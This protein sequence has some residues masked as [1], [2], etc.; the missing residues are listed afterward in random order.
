MNAKEFQIASKEK[1]I[2]RSEKGNF[3]SLHTES[4]SLHGEGVI[5]LGLD[6]GDVTVDAVGIADYNQNSGETTMN[7]TARFNMP[8]DKGAL[9]GI[10]D[11][12][13][14]EEDL[15]PLDY[16]RSTLE[17]ALIEWSDQKIADRVKSDYTIRGEVKKLPSQLE[18]SFVFT[19]LKLSSY[20]RRNSEE[21]G[22]ISNANTAVLVNIYEKPV[23]KFVPL[24]MFL[25][26]MGPLS[27]GDRFGFLID[28]PG[29]LEYYFDYTQ[30]KKDGS[31][32][33]IT[34]DETFGTAVNA[35]KE[36]KRKIK[37]FRYEITTQRVYLSKFMNLF[38]R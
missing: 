19:G 13:N 5:N 27:G 28:I 15:K 30:V 17:M 20:D 1:L 16:D 23:F 33:I 6:L 34:G 37:N 18:S 22:L 11:K 2:N 32:K 8:L 3:L 25:Q 14:K 7:L 10:A 24:K 9:Q 35:I 4:C 31:M 36:D 12:I 26:Q 29:G 21:R 38:E